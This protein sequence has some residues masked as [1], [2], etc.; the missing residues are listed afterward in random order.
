MRHWRGQK[1]ILYSQ[2]GGEAGHMSGYPRVE[3]SHVSGYPGGEAGHVSGYPVLMIHQALCCHL[4]LILKC[5]FSCLFLG[6]YDG[7]YE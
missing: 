6:K 4:R 5:T 7:N 1:D 3:S 2:P